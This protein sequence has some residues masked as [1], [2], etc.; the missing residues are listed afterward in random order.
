MTFGGG[1]AAVIVLRSAPDYP[2]NGPL[3]MRLMARRPRLHSII[4]IEPGGPRRKRDAGI[5]LLTDG[6][7]GP[8]ATIYQTAILINSYPVTQALT[9]MNKLTW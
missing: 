4:L 9:G 2:I 1:G 5:R 8:A 3:V 6:G 7:N